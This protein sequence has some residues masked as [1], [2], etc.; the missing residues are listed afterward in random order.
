GT[1]SAVASGDVASASGVLMLGAYGTGNVAVTVDNQ[2]SILAK[3]TG[4]TTASAIGIEAT[5]TKGDGIQIDNSGTIAAAAYGTG[6][7]ATGVSMVS[8]GDNMLTNSGTIGA[9][10]DG[11]RIAVFSSA[12]STATIVNKG[13]MI[14]AIVTGSG[15][16]SFTNAAGA[17]WHAVGSSDFGD[18]DDHVVNR[19]T[20]F[21]DDAAIHLGGFTNGNT[22]DNFGTIGVSGAGNAIDMDNPFP[23]SNNGVISF[24]DGA[25]DDIL[26]IAGDLAGAGS[27]NVD[28]SGL[29]QVSDRLYIDGNVLD[30]TKQTINV[31]LLDL[32]TVPSVDIPIVTATGTLGG[33]FTLGQIQ[34]LGK[35]FVTTD[36][37][38][39]TASGTVS[40][41]MDVTGLNDAGSLAS[42]VAPGVQN[43]VNSQIGTWR[44]R[45]GVVPEV[46]EF[47]L[48]PW[49]RLFSDSGDV[50]LARSGN[51]GPGGSD[52]FH[53]SNHGMEVG[54]DMRLVKHLSV[55]LVLGSADG[56]QNMAGSVGSNRLYSTTTGFYATWLSENHFYIDVSQ[57]WNNVQVR[58]RSAE[59]ATTTHASAATFNVEA[60]VT[61]WTM[62]GINVVPQVQYT[63]TRIDDIS[64]LN[65]QQS[66]FADRGGVS[67]RGRVGVALEKTIQGGN[68][69]W[70]PYG[71]VNAVREFNGK[72]DYAVNGGLLGST[73]LEGT[74]AMVELGL[75]AR[76]GG[77]S[78]TGGVNWTDG[79]SAQNIMG[80]QLVVRYN[81]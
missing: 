18:G 4:S 33:T 56:T 48:A 23:V 79:G 70:T 55:G 26:T 27:I 14:G 52:A 31:H 49:V 39:K 77:L 44:Q 65:V 2:G 20:L 22:F 19:G 5:G 21:M 9:Y 54:F 16:D 47:G 13:S 24:V 69:I 40:L 63:H 68:F 78:V 58:M 73:S 80:G 71:S 46:G 67:S 42:G 3:A 28:V 37:G 72:Y 8:V 30:S 7:T 25:T 81:W 6:A 62:A 43:L 75:G 45:M 10:G 61:A 1:I 64:Q 36:F 57:R 60:G 74:S 59:A 12:D 34:P 41:V 15:D 11:G 66:T 38:L 17:S 51:F 32:P 35:G 29:H 76:R 50:N 53:Q